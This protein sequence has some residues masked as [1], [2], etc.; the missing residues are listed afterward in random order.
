MQPMPRKAHPSPTGVPEAE[1]AA[2]SLHWLTSPAPWPISD[3]CLLAA[4]NYDLRG[5]L[6][7]ACTSLKQVR[8][9]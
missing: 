4:K 3:W 6:R 9:G 8:A 1:L 2:C 7:I 5:S